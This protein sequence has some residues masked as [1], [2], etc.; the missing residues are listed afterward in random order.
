[1]TTDVNNNQIIYCLYC[2]ASIIFEELG[3]FLNENPDTKKEVIEEQLQ[4]W[5]EAYDGAYLIQNVVFC[6]R[7]NMVSHF[8]DWATN[9]NKKKLK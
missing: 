1:M 7:C 6:P 4:L 8:D 9:D 3:E 5:G 2:K